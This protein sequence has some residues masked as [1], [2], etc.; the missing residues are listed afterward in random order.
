MYKLA[1]F[2]IDGTLVY[3]HN[4][5]HP[6]TLKALQALHRNKIL[7]FIATGRPLDM[8]RDLN[9]ALSFQFDGYVALNGQHI[10]DQQGTIALT[11]LDPTHIID[12]LAFLKAHNIGTFIVDDENTYVNFVNDDQDEEFL[13]IASRYQL[14]DINRLQ[15]HPIL[16]IMV[17]IHADQPALEKEFLSLMP[18]CK[19]ARWNQY[20]TD[21]IPRTG[22]KN[23]GIDTLLAYHQIDLSE[24]MAFG[25]GQNDIDMLKH[26]KIGVA[27]ENADSYVKKQA[28]HITGHVEE[29]GILKALKH[30]HLI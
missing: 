9:E 29:G 25:D 4:R 19:S 12:G 27:M 24:T 7:T 8:V 30:F 21:I 28:D 14:Y 3:D 5:Y 22:G 23:A 17:H 6:T 11:P 13:E 20:S 2:D 15:E 18:E 1:V 10:Y 16:Q 26:V